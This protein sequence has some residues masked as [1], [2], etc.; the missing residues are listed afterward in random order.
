MWAM[1]TML[2]AFLGSTVLFAA[3]PEG[4]TKVDAW[5]QGEEHWRAIEPQ[6]FAI[7]KQ[8]EHLG[9]G[10][11]F[12]GAPISLRLPIILKLPNGTAARITNVQKADR[13]ELATFRKPP[14]IV[15]VD[16]SITAVDTATHTV[17]IKAVGVWFG[18]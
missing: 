5:R 7:G 15:S 16:G 9:E 1:R 6:L 10:V 4:I 3:E 18:Q 8:K 11:C 12:S 17:T 2:V 14:T 13:D